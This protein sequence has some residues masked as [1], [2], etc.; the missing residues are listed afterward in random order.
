MFSMFNFDASGVSPRKG[1]FN[2]MDDIVVS[3]AEASSR[4]LESSGLK[5]TLDGSA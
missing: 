2:P 5:E 4:A 1:S 3:T